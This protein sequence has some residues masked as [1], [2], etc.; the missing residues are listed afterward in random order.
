MKNRIF[1][2]T[3]LYVTLLS[4]PLIGDTKKQSTDLSTA[5]SIDNTDIACY[6]RAV[7]VES[8][9]AM[10]EGLEGHQLQ[11]DIFAKRDSATAEVQERAKKNEKAK[12]IKGYNFSNFG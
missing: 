1:I 10:G 9:T 12:K 2:S 6:P 3:A 11:K 4:T 8:G 5:N 7:F